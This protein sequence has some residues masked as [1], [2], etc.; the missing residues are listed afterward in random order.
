MARRKRLT[1]AQRIAGAISAAVL[2]LAA[3]LLA[4]FSDDSPFHPA[5]ASAVAGPDLMVHVIDVGNADSLLVT[6]QGST[7]LIDAGENDDGDTVIAYLRSH[8]VKKLDYVIATHPDADHIGGM[9]DVVEA[10]PIGTFL[11]S[12]LSDDLTPTTKTYLDLLEALE[13]KNVAVTEAEPGQRYALGGA[14]LSILGPA[15]SFESANSMS[16]VCRVDYGRRGFLFM[17]DAEKDAEN[18]LL[19][20]G[21]NLKA[22]VLKLGH[23]GSKTSSQEAL[24]RAVSP[25]YAAITCGAGNRYSHP[26][27]EVL[28]RLKSLGITPYRCDLDGTIVFTTDGA[29]SLTVHT[30][31]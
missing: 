6:N 23:H 9:D 14:S 31:K 18:A 27:A 2:L 8:G 21:A 19:E 1:P 20:S 16:V 3:G 7:L 10:F 29:D 17:G 15:G 30:A 13:D 28:G 11:M 25:Q 22:D 12:F 5:A 4:W 26:N 24:L